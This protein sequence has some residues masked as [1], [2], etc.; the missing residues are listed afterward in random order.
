MTS[1]IRLESE[2]AS[3]I[4]TVRWTKFGSGAPLVFNHGTPFSSFVWHDIAQAL[5]SRYTV[6]LWDMP[7]YGSSA[8]YE[9]QRVSLDYQGKL[10]SQ[11]LLHWM[12][13][14]T[15]LPIVIAHDFGGAVALRAHL[16][17]NAKY[18]ALALVDPVAM[19][20]LGSPLFRLLHDNE[21][22]FN[23]LPR[24]IHSAL[25]HEYISSAS[26]QGLSTLAS[27]TLLAP[28][29]TEEGQP[30]FYRQIAQHQQSFIEEIQ[31]K[32]KDMTSCPIL[33]CWGCDDSWIP[34]SNGRSLASRIPNVIY[35]EI[36]GAGHLVPLDKPAHLTAHLMD[37]LYQVT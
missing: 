2:F 28:W 5:S 22:V 32:Y 20:P 25:V 16:L 8:M 19:L 33:L 12:Q 35:R 30:A 18:R 11:L 9:G 27:Q 13:D 15:E 4:G 31:P 24:N 3:D 1:H 36:P 23:K 26:A 7:G 17:H 29:L 10:F 21:Q 14:C 6:Y 34:V 37:F